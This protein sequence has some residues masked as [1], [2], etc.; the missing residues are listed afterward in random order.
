MYA[1]TPFAAPSPMTELLSLSANGDV[2][3]SLYGT[4][5]LNLP[6]TAVLGKSTQR[7]C[8]RSVRLPS[9]PRHARGP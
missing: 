8:T 9:S 6:Q 3:H 1:V 5:M 7:T 4:P 2:F